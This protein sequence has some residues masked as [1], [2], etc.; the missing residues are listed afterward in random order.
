MSRGVVANDGGAGHGVSQ[1]RARRRVAGEVAI[2]SFGSGG[3]GTLRLEPTEDPMTEPSMARV[4]RL[5]K[6]DDGDVL[7]AVAEAVLRLLMEANVAGVIGAGRHERSPERLKRPQR[8][9]RPHARPPA[10]PAPAAQPEAAPGLVLPAL[11]RARKTRSKRWSPSSRRPESAVD[12]L[13]QAMGLTGISKL[14]L[15]RARA[16]PGER[17]N[18]EPKRRADVVGLS[19]SLARFAPQRGLDRPPGRRRAAAAADTMRL[20]PKAA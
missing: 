1:A 9:S 10:R 13:V 19:G 5:E 16:D 6:A 14:A 4:E 2:G 8:T 3:V 15:G 20:P 12:D 17:L 18:K 11:S 7:R